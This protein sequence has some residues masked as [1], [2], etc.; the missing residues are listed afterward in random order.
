ML[1]RAAAAQWGA[2]L[3]TCIAED[4]AIVHRPSQRRLPYGQ[5]T[6]AAAA[7]GRPSGVRLK[8][9]SQFR[10]IGRSVPRMDAAPK[11]LGSAVFGLDVERPGLLTAVLVRSP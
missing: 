6:V 2:E 9:P 8:P 10:V 4:G 3:D 1:R 5:L 11:A 7:V